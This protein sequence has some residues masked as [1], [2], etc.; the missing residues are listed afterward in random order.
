V[1]AQA[2]QWAGIWVWNTTTWT[3]VGEPLAAHSLTVTQLSFSPDG[4]QLLSVSRDRSFAIFSRTGSGAL[5]P[6]CPSPR[7]LIADP[8]GRICLTSLA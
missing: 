3:H 4:S 1:Q 2:A 7:T 6:C 8:I 5:L